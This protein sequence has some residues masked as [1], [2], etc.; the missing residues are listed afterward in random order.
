L[1]ISG[2]QTPIAALSEDGVGDEHAQEQRAEC[3]ADD[4]RQS[5]T[6]KSAE[7]AAL[8]FDLAGDGDADQRDE[9]Q[10]AGSGDATSAQINRLA[11][12]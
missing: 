1:S 9:D 8:V 6:R 12:L 3:A 5:M 11:W 2:G 4:Q 7:L 10:R